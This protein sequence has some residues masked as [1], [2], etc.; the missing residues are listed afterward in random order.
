MFMEAIVSNYRTSY[1]KTKHAA[2]VQRSDETI[3]KLLTLFCQIDGI[4]VTVYRY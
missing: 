4:F 3:F 2:C 1:Y